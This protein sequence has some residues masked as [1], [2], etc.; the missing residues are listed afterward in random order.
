MPAFLLDMAPR[1]TS[2]SSF[3]PAVAARQSACD[4]SLAAVIELVQLTAGSSVDADAPL[5]EAGV[6]SLGAVELRNQLQRA[7]GDTTALSS[8]LMFDHPTARL[9]TLHLQGSLSS[10]VS[11]SSVVGARKAGEAGVQ[12]AGVSVA[13][14]TA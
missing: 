11:R 8:T 6:D 10:A 5:M 9:V 7:I 14:P 2:V 12:V 4:V 1:S 13:L 3:T